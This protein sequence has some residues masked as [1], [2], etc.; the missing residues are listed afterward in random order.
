MEIRSCVSRPNQKQDKEPAFGMTE[1][2][3]LTKEEKKKNTKNLFHKWQYKKCPSH[4]LLGFY[5]LYICGDVIANS[6]M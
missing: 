5:E 4:L 6:G 1:G 2:W 3:V